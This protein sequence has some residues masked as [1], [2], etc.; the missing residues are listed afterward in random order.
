MLMQFKQGLITDCALLIDEIWNNYKFYAL[1]RPT[2]Q[3]NSLQQSMS[4]TGAPE[5][6]ASLLQTR[7]LVVPEF[8]CEG[9]RTQQSDNSFSGHGI[10]DD[11]TVVFSKHIVG[12]P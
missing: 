6:V 7:E 3:Q 1:Q 8:I 11:A 9:K 4:N 10:K 2:T 12:R 5:Q